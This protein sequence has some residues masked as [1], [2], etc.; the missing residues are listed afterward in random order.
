[1]SQFYDLTRERRW[2]QRE[3]SRLRRSMINR[4]GKLKANPEA[5]P[6]Y[7]SLNRIY[8]L[9]IAGQICPALEAQARPLLIR[10]Y[11]RGLRDSALFFS[12]TL[13][14]YIS[15]IVAG[16]SLPGLLLPVFVLLFLI[17]LITMRNT[18]NHHEQVLKLVKE[19]YPLHD[20]KVVTLIHPQPPVMPPPF[21]EQGRSLVQRLADE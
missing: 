16:H 14:I 8:E 21:D 17:H 12:A 3:M 19:Q 6:L 2:L 11:K 13:L 20:D 1:M 10:A 15:L 5:E 4:T 7:A 9:N 18:I